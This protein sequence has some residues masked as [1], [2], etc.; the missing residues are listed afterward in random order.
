MGKEVVPNNLNERKSPLRN[1]LTRRLLLAGTALLGASP[2]VIENYP[3]N[4]SSQSAPIVSRSEHTN[5]WGGQI[6]NVEG[7]VPIGNNPD[8]N[9]PESPQIVPASENINF[10]GG[11][12]IVDGRIPTGYVLFDGTSGVLDPAEVVRLRGLAMFKGEPQ[13]IITLPYK[14]KYPLP[15]P[16]SPKHPEQHPQLLK[17]PKEIL[18]KEQL[19]ER[20]IYII[21]S[22]NTQLYIRPQAFEE[23]GPLARFD[24]GSR[25]KITIVFVDGPAVSKRFMQ[26][27]KYDPVRHLIPEDA[28]KSSPEEYRMRQIKITQENI[29][30]LLQQINFQRS[31]I[32]PDQNAIE[33]LLKDL[34]LVKIRLFFLENALPPQLKNE[35]FFSSHKLYRTGAYVKGLE[36]TKTK[37]NSDLQIKYNPHVTIFLAV[38]DVSETPNLVVY[39]DN[40]G[41]LQ[42]LAAHPSG[43]LKNFG[44]KPNQARPNPSDFP[45]NPAASKEKPGTYPYGGGYTLAFNLLHELE[46]DIFTAKEHEDGEDPIVNEHDMDMLAM[47]RTR[48]AWEKWQKDKDDSGYYFIFRLPNGVHILTTR[49]KGIPNTT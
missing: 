15:V 25:K 43:N 2:A 13:I 22:K 46:H 1:G 11:Q 29:S 35:E 14:G 48:K 31:L 34:L 5:F 32:V 39:F 21:Q 8:N 42:T 27:T 30:A 6:N 49:P 3:D 47:E 10:W 36:L 19:E 4:N 16:F 44:P 37:P 38:G 28:I 26:D 20:G 18:S 17:L 9:L 23:D 24:D 12:I 7:G 45:I 41:S 33:S 40:N